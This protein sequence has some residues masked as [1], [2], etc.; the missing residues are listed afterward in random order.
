[1]VPARYPAYSRPPL[2]LLALINGPIALWGVWRLH[3]R[4]TRI[5]VAAQVTL[6]LWAW[7]VG[8][9]PYLV[10]PDITIGLAAAPN[11]T[12]TS[13]LVVIGIGMLLLLPSLWFLFHVFKARNPAANC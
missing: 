2:L 6:V 7:A 4:V 11:S 10:P 12:L 8:Q 3:P 1:M 13:L 9:W 5:A